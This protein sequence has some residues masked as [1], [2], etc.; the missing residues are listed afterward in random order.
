ML[1]AIGIGDNVVDKYIHQGMMYPGGNALNFSV[2]AKKLGAQAAYMGI[3]G[4]DEAA[5]HIKAVLDEIGIDYSRSLS[6]H[7]PNGFARVSLED[8][9][10]VF[11]PGNKG[12]V[13]KN[14]PPSFDPE[15]LAYIKGFDIL[16]TSC[17]SYI[18]P[19]LETL[20]STGVPISFD[21][22]DRLSDAYLSQ[23]GKSI[24]FAFL[25]CGDMETS[26]VKEKV[27]TAVQ[28]GCVFAVASR[29]GK[30]AL[31]FN[32]EE[33][34][35]QHAFLVKPVDTMGA[36]DSFLAGM[37]IDLLGKDALFTKDPELIK[38]SMDFAARKAA[39]T[40]MVNGTFGYGKTYESSRT[41]GVSHKEG[42][43]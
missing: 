33:Y 42:L 4:D 34:I 28:A 5:S 24:Q 18:E 43:E 15:D 31:F 7:G 37:L 35:E 11:L 27:K 26:Q 2:F 14:H 16:H 3:F 25:S 23:V 32:G 21:F 1:K 41:M 17:Y 8:G 13:S 22:S 40:C 19:Q 20:A 39:Q 29:G 9:E 36:G 38:E 6:L 30:G 12:G 10:R